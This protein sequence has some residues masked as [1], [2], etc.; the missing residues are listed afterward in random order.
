[1]NKG[2]EVR[3]YAVFNDKVVARFRN[4]SSAITFRQQN[5]KYYFGRLII[6][7]KERYNYEKSEKLK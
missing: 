1:M 7:R 2:Y 6:M 3:W 4:K 5:N